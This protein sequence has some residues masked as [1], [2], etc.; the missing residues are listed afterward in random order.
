MKRFLS[1]V[2]AVISVT[3]ICVVTASANEPG[4]EPI[5][6]DV[7]SDTLV[8]VKYGASDVES[9]VTEM[10]QT[11]TSQ[12]GFTGYT[13][14]EWKDVPTKFEVGG[15][16]SVVLSKGTEPD[17]IL[18]TFKVE[19]VIKNISYKLEQEEVPSIRSIDP[20]NKT[21][22]D[23][24]AYMNSNL[25]LVDGVKDT[26]YDEALGKADIE[27]SIPAFVPNESFVYKSLGGTTYK[28]SQEYNGHVYEKTCTVSIMTPTAPNISFNKKT[29]TFSTTDVGVEY[30]TNQTNFY[31]MG[32]SLNAGQL[33]NAV[34]Y[35]FRKAA[36]TY[37]SPSMVTTIAVP[38]KDGRYSTPCNVYVDSSSKT[39]RYSNSGNRVPEYSV[40]NYNWT[41]CQQDM[42]IQEAWYGKTLYFRLP[43]TADFYES[44]RVSV[45]IPY[46]QSKPSGTLTLD[47]TA[48]TVT[49][50]N[51]DSFRSC[52]FSI[53]AGV[54]WK[55]ASNNTVR[56]ENLKASTN[57]TVWARYYST[58]SYFASEYTSASITT[59]Q[60]NANKAFDVTETT[61]GDSCYLTIDVK[62]T[63]E[64]SGSN[65]TADITEV[66]LSN[67]AKKAQEMTRT[68]N[69]YATIYASVDK[70][71]FSS[72]NTKT[73][74]TVDSYVLSTISRYCTLKFIYVSD[75]FDIELSSIPNSGK[76]QMSVEDIR[77]FSSSSKLDY[78]TSTLNSGGSVYKVTFSGNPTVKYST[79]Y[80]LGYSDA[81]D[82]I[83]IWYMDLNGTKTQVQTIYRP[84]SSMAIFGAPTNGYILIGKSSGKQVTVPFTDVSGNWALKYIAYCYDN[85]IFKG[86]SPT[87]FAPTE[88]VTKGQMIALI[89]RV[90]KV[91]DTGYTPTKFSQFKD[92]NGK[93]WF[94]PYLHWALS[95]SIYINFDNE[96]NS[97]AGITREE[98]ANILYNYMCYS[99]G[100][101]LRATVTS[102]YNDRSQIKTNNT[103]AVDYLAQVGI[104]EGDSNKNFNP[105]G[106]ITR[107]EMAT[108]LY[109]LSTVG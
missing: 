31:P 6:S 1:I 78:I 12:P 94:A 23:L 92:L 100:T 45:D 27:T 20:Q 84:S 22:T 101:A 55:R 5:S 106:T 48:Y 99:K 38:G 87:K 51:Y 69:V 103:I 46:R 4:P 8:D 7:L 104:M 15:A 72:S 44:T 105:T 53:D 82:S 3:V 21:K 13:V 35:Y 17:V 56:W 97:A 32:T 57:Y 86:V 25:K 71:I 9:V 75:F 90:G 14:V 28:M 91:S 63:P 42:Q 49:V 40:D 62:V 29:L 50:S 16:M 11:I 66:M 58:S 73:T 36:T 37:E 70:D 19:Y 33:E 93:E 24:V 85:N 64:Y 80:N 108:I 88:K 34:T 18:S 102:N 74:L 107:A 47:A 61:D 43:A 76:L 60:T 26:G 10:K 54:N 65:V 81:L 30:S 41:Q 109:R 77:T 39:I 89:A 79:V 67:L 98:I 52:E 95:N 96:F 2:L 68:K 83:N 59:L